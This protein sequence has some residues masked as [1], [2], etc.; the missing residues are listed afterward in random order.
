MAKEEENIE[1]VDSEEEQ[2][3]E[4]LK[5]GDELQE[6]VEEAKKEKKRWTEELEKEV[7]MRAAKLEERKEVIARLEQTG[8][9]PDVEVTEMW[10]K[11]GEEAMQ[12]MELLEETERLEKEEEVIEV[13]TDEEDNDEE[14]GETEVT[15]VE[16]I[17]EEIGDFKRVT[18]LRLRGGGEF[19]DAEEM[20]PE[21]EEAGEEREVG[22]A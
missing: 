19:S 1:D 3:K 17:E 7:E 5:L 4:I 12:I 8:E 13:T 15:D 11:L 6:N 16:E 20:L 9:L 21:S 22:V 18:V 14:E 2:M 10:M